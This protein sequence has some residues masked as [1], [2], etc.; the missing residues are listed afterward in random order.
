MSHAEP[1]SAGTQERSEHT[2]TA[3]VLP[4]HTRLS[5][6]KKSGKVGIGSRRLGGGGS[7]FFW[8]RVLNG[9]DV[10]LEEEFCGGSESEEAGRRL[11]FFSPPPPASP[12]ERGAPTGSTQ[13]CGASSAAPHSSF[14]PPT[15]VFSLGGGAQRESGRQEDHV[16][17]I[18]GFYLNC[19]SSHTLDNCILQIVIYLSINHVIMKFLWSFNK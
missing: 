14:L 7:D 13:W 17:I 9:P 10:P 15:Q 4:T 19:Y 11:F 8:E 16:W 3:L 12:P 5:C 6:G 1:L 2:H 18:L